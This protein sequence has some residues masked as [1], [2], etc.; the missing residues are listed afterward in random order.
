MK[1]ITKEQL[2]DEA[3]NWENNFEEIEAPLY[4]SPSEQDAYSIGQ[5][6]GL[7]E[8]SEIQKF[9]NAFNVGLKESMNSNELTENV[10]NTDVLNTITSDSKKFDTFLNNIDEQFL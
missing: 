7:L 3:T 2:L 10:S 5:K 8:K 1:K 4:E 9:M 6:I